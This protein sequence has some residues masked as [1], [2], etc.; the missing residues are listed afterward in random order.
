M[1]NFLWKWKIHS[2]K[3]SKFFQILGILNK[4]FK[5]TLVQKYLRII[6]YNALAACILLYISETWTLRQKDKKWLSSIELKFFWRT[7]GHTLFDQKLNE[8]ILEEL[9]AEPVGKKLRL[10]KSNCPWHV[11]RMNNNRMPKV[12]PKYRPHGWRWLGRPLKRLL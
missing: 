3:T 6:V 11:T 10:Y 1:W 2:T 7:A 5:P 8:E 9:K 4:T 12:M